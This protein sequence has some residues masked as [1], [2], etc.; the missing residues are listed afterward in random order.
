MIENQ[1]VLC[2]VAGDCHSTGFPLWNTWKEFY[3][4]S[5]GSCATK[6]Q[7]QSSDLAQCESGAFKLSKRLN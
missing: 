1:G 4:C 5:E 3:L 6:R 2:V 7:A